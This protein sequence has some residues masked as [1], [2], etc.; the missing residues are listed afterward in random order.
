MNALFLRVATCLFLLASSTLI[1]T[2]DTNFSL[3]HQKASNVIGQLENGL[4]YHLISPFNSKNGMLIQLSCCIPTESENASL[5]MLMQHALF[6]G[7]H[8][9]SRLEL[10]QALDQLGL[11]I[12]GDNCIQ[13]NAKVQSIQFCLSEEQIEST[14]NV[15]N[16]L[17]EIVFRASLTDEGIE[18]ARRHLLDKIDPAK[19]E[20]LL[21]LQSVTAS[22]V[23]EFYT[24]WYRPERI[25]LIAAGFNDSEHI[26]HMF[27]TIFDSPIKTVTVMEKDQIVDE[28]NEVREEFSLEL[29]SN[30]TMI[31]DGKIRMNKPDFFNNRFYSHMV[32]RCLTV[33]GIAGLVFA[34]PLAGVSMAPAIVAATAGGISTMSGVYLL[35]SDYI[36]DPYFVEEVRKQD[37]RCGCAHAYQKNRAGITLTPFERR[38]L[39]L[40]EMVDHPQTL[41]NLPILILTDLYRLNDPIIAELFTEDEFNILH[42]MKKDFTHQRNQYKM[43][44]DNLEQELYSLTWPFAIVRD[45]ALINARNLYD[46]NYYV[47]NKRVLTVQLE[48]EIKKIEQAYIRNEISY[49]DKK[50]LIKEAHDYFDIN[51]A[52]LQGGLATAEYTLKKMQREIHANYDFQVEICKRSIDYNARKS[53]YSQGEKALTLEYN[54]ELTDILV[55]FPVELTTLPDYMDLTGL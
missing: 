11:D 46:Q 36:K 16:L 25:Q 32:G 5:E 40:Q 54:R 43:L 26:L 35:Y 42:Q 20:E 2:S 1:A 8:D 24:Q 23:R 51:M 30:N 14:H 6:Y 34:C 15:L 29:A 37:L 13:S 10:A 19:A 44:N 3:Q 4:T 38:V 7:T 21:S 12:D 31:I 41:N 52:S 18:M 9:K 55:L 39:F 50:I 17:Y 33:V 49:D 48:A 47:V 28:F 27:S 45:N 53:I 22:E